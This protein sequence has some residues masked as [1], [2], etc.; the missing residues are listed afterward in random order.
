MNVTK[1]CIEHFKAK[2]REIP[3]NTVKT[4]KDPCRAYTNFIDV[5][6]AKK[7]CTAKNEASH[8]MYKGLF[9]NISPKSGKRPHKYSG[10]LISFQGNKIFQEA[11]TTNEFNIFIK[12]G[13]EAASKIPETTH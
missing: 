3:W 13:P 7:I 5:C 9:E 12:V 8:K 10:K 4:F 6:T 2:L 11:R 1:T